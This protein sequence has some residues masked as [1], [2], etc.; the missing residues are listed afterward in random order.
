LDK[1]GVPTRPR[2]RLGVLPGGA[3]MREKKMMTP[4]DAG[5]GRNAPTGV[6]RQGRSRS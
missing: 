2:L 4:V 6:D 3:A 1:R 5:G